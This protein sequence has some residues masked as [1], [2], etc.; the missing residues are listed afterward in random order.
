MKRYIAVATVSAVMLIGLAGCGTKERDELRAKVEQ[1]DKQVAKV[2]SDI[3]EKDKAIAELTEKLQANDEALKQ[4]QANVEALTADLVKI[5]A[6]RY[7]LKGGA[8]AT[9][10]K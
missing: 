7:K 1:L 8:G 2:T 9:K 3:G 10:K 4:A 5:K 6:E